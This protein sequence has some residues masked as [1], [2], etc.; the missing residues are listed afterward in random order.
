MKH[1]HDHDDAKR[2]PN[3]ANQKNKKM[4]TAEQKAEKPMEESAMGSS[5]RQ[6]SKPNNMDPKSGM[7]PTNKHK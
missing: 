5:K 4:H 7:H 6:G 3:G 2:Q 1:D